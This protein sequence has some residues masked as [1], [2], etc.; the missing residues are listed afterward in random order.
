MKV[1]INTVGKEYNATA[2]SI[3]EGLD[4]IG[5][6]WNDI[7]GKGTIIVS[8]GKKSYEHLFTCIQMRRLFGNKL[9]KG[10]WAKRLEILLNLQ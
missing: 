10:L 9:A 1:K 3:E 7:K 4:K 8:D 6:D 2:K 5:L